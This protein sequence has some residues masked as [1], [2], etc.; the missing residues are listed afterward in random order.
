MFN[1]E[2]S[3]HINKNEFTNKMFICVSFIYVYKYV[4]DNEILKYYESH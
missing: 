1:Y 4:K 3:V 2:Y